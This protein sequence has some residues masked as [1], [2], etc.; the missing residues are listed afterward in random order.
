MGWLGV[1]GWQ[2]EGWRDGR[3][4]GRVDTCSGGRGGRRVEMKEGGHGFRW[5]EGGREV[6]GGDER[7]NV[8]G[9][10]NG[11]ERRGEE[12]KGEV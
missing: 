3:K 2:R 6:E 1:G 9:Q 12:G 11:T 8:N 5:E 4:G 7:C 10:K